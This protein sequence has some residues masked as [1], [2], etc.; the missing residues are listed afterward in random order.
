ML[1]YLMSGSFMQLYAADRFLRLQIKLLLL[2]F[3]KAEMV[4]Q[5]LNRV[6]TPCS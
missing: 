4:V 6:H 5:D 1:S 2:Y 3:Q